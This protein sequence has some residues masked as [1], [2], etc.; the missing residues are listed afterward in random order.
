MKSTVRRGRLVLAALMFLAAASVAASEAVPSAPEFH[1]AWE[2]WITLD[3]EVEVDECEPYNQD[4]RIRVSRDAEGY[5]AVE[6]CI[7]DGG[8][9]VPAGDVRVEVRG[10]VARITYLLRDLP[11]EP[12][13]P[14]AGCSST[15]RLLVR[16]DPVEAAISSVEI[17]GFRLTPSGKARSVSL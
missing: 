11:L 10:G 7:V 14:V 13:Q 2:P 5:L 12:M 16:I 15:P 4:D 1:G 3:A 8:Q 17:R 9:Y 6:H